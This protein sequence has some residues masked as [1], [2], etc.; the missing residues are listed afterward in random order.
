[1]QNNNLISVLIATYNRS[2][3]LKDT[4]DSLL[5]LECNGSYDYEVIIADN[6]SKDKT[7]DVVEYY[8]GKF[9]GRLRYLFEPIQGKSYALNSAINVAKG[10]IIAFTD[11]DVIVDKQWLT[12]IKN[13]FRNTE[14]GIVGGI[15][16]PIW[17]SKKPSW[18]TEKFYGKLGLQNYGDRPFVTS[19]N[20][21]LPFGASYAFRKELFYKYGLFDERM[22]FAHDTEI[23]NRFLNNGVKFGYN[24]S[25]VVYHKVDSPRLRKNY[26]YKWFYRR[27]KMFNHIK[28]PSLVNILIGLLDKFISYI[29]CKLKRD[30]ENAFYHE[31]KIFYLLGR[32]TGNYNA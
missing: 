31:T 1:M 30:E 3:S 12:E 8:Q 5:N 13:T 2:E 4:L 26:F 11:D 17:L 21:Q 7:K 22:R 20:A 28:K 27:G 24:P 29:W 14:I 19:S 32:L 6:N 18:L 25:L 15:I 10:K 16:N 9:E 23:C